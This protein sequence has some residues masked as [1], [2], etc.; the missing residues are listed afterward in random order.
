[1]RFL[2]SASGFRSKG[3]TVGGSGDA[4]DDAER[5]ED[6]TIFLIE[7]MKSLGVTSIVLG[8]IISFS[9]EEY[10]CG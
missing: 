2:S 10:I 1:M 8:L 7:I 4:P 9:V 6:G 3:S 5:S